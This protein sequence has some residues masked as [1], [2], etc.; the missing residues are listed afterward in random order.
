[1]RALCWNGVND[2]A[3][4]T[5]DDPRITNPHDVIVQ[6]RLTT[7]CGSDL[8][9]IN[10]YL[11]GMKEGDVFGHE[12]MGEVIET[13]SEVTQTSVGA[14]VVV[15]S[16]I[17]C[18]SCWYCDRD[19]YSVCDTT[20]PNAELQQPVFGFPTGGIYGYTHPFGGYQGSHAE[21]IRVPFGDVNCFAVPEGITDEQAL[22][23]SDAV[24]T[25]L[26][27][28]EFCD[29]SPGDTVAVWGSGGVGVMAAHS[30]RL[31]G[32]ERVIVIDRFPERLQLARNVVGAET[33]DYSRVDSVR[34]ALREATGGRG[35]DSCIDAV[36][37]EGHGTGVQ[38]LYD[39]AKQ[40]LRLETDRAT[41]LRQ[42][43]LACRKGGVV[44]VLGVYG[45][46]DKFPMGLI[47]N[48]SLTLRSAQQHGQRY[49]PRMFDYVLQGDLDPS[50]LITH[51]MPLADAV[52][53][54]ELFK[55]KK[56]G[57][58]RAVFRP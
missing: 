55:E 27:G 8:H 2:L 14:R 28:A 19:L 29:I 51:D 23:L 1:M 11:P 25:G 37:M 43:V 47:T 42:A 46:T 53:G 35:P 13:G 17:G 18:K 20:N 34:E 45:L 39:R 33:I 52:R 30:A 38:Q 32:A 5:V 12:F 48:K 22:F 31:L 7:T 36:G 16:F 57:C 40:L 56:D 21:Y 3:V 26:M 15:P 41:S 10:G 44:S 6:V 4:E 9:F 58:V 49:M 50:V 54:Y 24:P